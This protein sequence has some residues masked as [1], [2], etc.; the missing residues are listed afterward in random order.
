LNRFAILWTEIYVDACEATHIRGEQSTDVLDLRMGALSDALQDLRAL[1]GQ[2]SAATAETVE[3]AVNAA[4]ALG[5]LERC[6][7]IELLRAII[8]PPEDSAQRDEVERLRL[9]LSEVRAQARVGHVA[10]G[11]KAA[12]ALESHAR[13]VAYPPLLAE[14]LFTAGMMHHEV[15]DVERSA[16]M[17]EDAV[18]TAEMC[19]HDEVIAQAAA[20]LVFVQG[21]VQARFDAGE[22]WG[23]HAE[24]V[25]NRMG[26]HDQIRGWL[27]NNRGVMRS[28]QGRLPDAI[29]DMHLAIAA[30][31]K[32][33]GPDDP[34]VGLSLVNVAVFLDDLGKTEQGATFAERAVHTL[35]KSLGLEHPTVAIGLTN[36]AEILNRLGRFREAGEHA[37]RALAV[38]ERETDPQ[39]LYVTYPLYALAVS[40]IGTGDFEIALPLIERA[41][42][43]REALETSLAKLAEVHFAFARAWLGVG[44]DPARAYEL[45]ERARNEYRQAPAT[46]ATARELDEID[47]WLCANAPSRAVA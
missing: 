35:A 44:H 33:L 24:T 11:L 23:R 41:V 38:F 46:P 21:R 22:I 36:Y 27:F 29:D 6:S 45:A 26:G 14:V 39:G 32:V 7:D 42:R 13:R 43:I 12:V 8:R 10:S 2:F 40:H 30:K 18:W 20:N 34:D 31:E 3:N 28:V 37:S 5:N 17:L 1:C 19:R 16:A 15:G 9:R 25:L 4:N 47:K